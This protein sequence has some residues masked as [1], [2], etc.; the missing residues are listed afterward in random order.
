MLALHA[1][2]A[3]TA[4][5]GAADAGA[6]EQQQCSVE[7]LVFWQWQLALL[8]ILVQVTRFAVVCDDA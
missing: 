3:G 4:C 5:A 2:D 1:A 7:Y 6:A 8:K